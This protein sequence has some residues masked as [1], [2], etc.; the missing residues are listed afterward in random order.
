MSDVC[1]KVETLSPSPLL[2]VFVPASEFGS[3]FAEEWP[4]VCWE[5]FP[6]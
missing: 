1:D 2:D 6:L 3:A 5:W 4:A